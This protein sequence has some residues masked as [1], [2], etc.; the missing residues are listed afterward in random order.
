M[1]MTF[2]VWKQSGSFTK[3][4]EVLKK[5]VDDMSEYFSKWHLQPSTS[6]TVCNVL[7]LHSANASR[8]LNIYLK[9]QRVKHDII[10]AYLGVTL[11]RSLKYHDHLQKTAAKVST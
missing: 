4:E 8:E 9:D 2:C 7:H 5:Y 6:K 3:I 11:D 1:L 10:P